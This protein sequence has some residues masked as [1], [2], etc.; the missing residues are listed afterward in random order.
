LF[1]PPFGVGF[2][3]ACVIGECQPDVAM[4]DIWTYMFALLVAVIIIA[5]VPWLSTGFL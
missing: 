1:S 5:C 3:G 4:R 2:Y